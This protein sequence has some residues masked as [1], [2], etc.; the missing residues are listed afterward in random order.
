MNDT[1][2]EESDRVY[3]R[4]AVPAADHLLFQTELANFNPFAE[5]AV[6]VRRTSGRR[7]YWSPA[8]SITSFRRRWSRPTSGYTANR[9]R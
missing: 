7:C 1:T 6:N 3:D 2:R 5:T 4:Y 8:S 9:W